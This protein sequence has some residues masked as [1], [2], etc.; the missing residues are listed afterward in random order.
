MPDDI[1][2]HSTPLL[3][4]VALAVFLAG[5]AALVVAFAHT[6]GAAPWFRAGG[7]AWIAAYFVV[8]LDNFS[9]KLPVQTRGGVLRREDGLLKYA[10]PYVFMAVLGL[11]ALVVA[12][13]A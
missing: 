2:S 6:E 1:E 4:R 11:G 12:V 8:L 10:G 5:A 3:P 13:F 9:R 7:I